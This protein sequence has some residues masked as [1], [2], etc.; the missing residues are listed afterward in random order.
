MKSEVWGGSYL[1]SDSPRPSECTADSLGT[2]YHKL[3]SRDHW[4]DT[5]SQW[6]MDGNRLVLLGGGVLG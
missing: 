6:S 3:R 4:A 1:L 5:V 2:S